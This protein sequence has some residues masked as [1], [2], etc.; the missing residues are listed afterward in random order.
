MALSPA[1]LAA[2]RTIPQDPDRFL[3][4]ADRLQS[5]GDLRGELITLQAR[6]A[7]SPETVSLAQAEERS[8]QDPAKTLLGRLWTS[9]SSYI[10]HWELGF[11]RHALIWAQETD[12]PQQ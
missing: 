4:L 1:V 8:L 11:I 3:V 9:P 5:E 2:L 6:R 10:P 7:E 12:E